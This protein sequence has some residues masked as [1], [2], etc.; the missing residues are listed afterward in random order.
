MKTLRV[1]KVV[2]VGNSCAVIIPSA[3]ARAL[4][5]ER[6]D[7]VTFGVFEDDVICVRKLQQED[8]AKLRPQQIMYE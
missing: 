2:K 4:K 3:I 8:I 5:I 6:G 1:Q 7:Q